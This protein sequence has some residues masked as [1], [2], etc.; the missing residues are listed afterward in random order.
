MC[1]PCVD[2]SKAKNVKQIPFT[3]FNQLKKDIILQYLK[4][5]EAGI[6]KQ[7]YQIEKR[8]V[9]DPPDKDYILA[10]THSLQDIPLSEKETVRIIFV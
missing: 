7:L 2:K 4:L 8:S 10:I 1:L 9:I 6:L 3:T 5:K